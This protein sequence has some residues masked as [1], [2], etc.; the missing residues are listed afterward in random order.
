MAKGIFWHITW[1]LY[2][3]VYLHN[4]CFLL[5]PRS[6][7]FFIF[8]FSSFW[9]TLMHLLESCWKLPS[10]SGALRRVLYLWNFH[11]LLTDCQDFG[12]YGEPVCC[13]ANPHPQD[14]ART[15]LAPTKVKNICRTE[16][17]SLL[18][19]WCKDRVSPGQSGSQQA[20]YQ[21]WPHTFFRWG[22]G[23]KVREEVDEVRHILNIRG[24]I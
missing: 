19:G 16:S 9:I 8:Y 5:D 20:Q 1:G 3:H 15:S 13:L 24:D 7:F 14:K 2:V 21:K 23:G 18:G 17:Y 4:F 12:C 10:F 6:L 22:V 11:E